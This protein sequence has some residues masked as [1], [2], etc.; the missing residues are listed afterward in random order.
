MIHPSTELRFIDPQMGY[1]VFATELIPKGTI[2]YVE[3]ELDLRI[4]ETEYRNHQPM[5]KSVL[6]KYTYINQNGLRIMCWDF[7]K[8]MNH[9]CSSSTIVTVYG[10]EIATRDIQIGEELTTEYGILNI[11]SNLECS[12]G[13]PDC[14]GTIRNSDLP[15]LHGR[16]DRIILDAL[17]SLKNVAQP[18][19]SLIDEKTMQD[20]EKCI[21]DPTHYLSILNM[22]YP[23]QESV[24]EE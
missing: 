22:Y 6:D 2:I 24:L 1:G 12:C 18:L 13:S 4:S 20:V 14:R 19:M 21:E 23:Y 8:Y 3:D 11:E 16:W 15:M 17:S 7:G 9:S 10:F 5:I